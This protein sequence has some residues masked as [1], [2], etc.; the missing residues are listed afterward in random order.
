MV[1][2]M[3]R[4]FLKGANLPAFLWGEAVRHSIY[5]LNR[6]PTR[7]LDGRTPYEAWCGN[8]PDLTHLR[9]FG[10]TAFMK[11]QSVHVR[12][13]DDR[14]KSVVYIDKEPGTKGCRLYDPKTG[15]IHVSRDV[16]CQEGMF[17]PWKREE[18]GEVTFPWNYIEINE[19]A[20]TEES[21]E[22]EQEPMTPLQ[23][24]SSQSRS[25]QSSSQQTMPVTIAESSAETTGG[26]SSSSTSSEPEMYRLLSDVEEPTSY[27]EAAELEEWGDA[28]KSEFETIEKNG[29][30]ALTNW[31][32][33]GV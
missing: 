12:K 31:S 16:V 10:C 2:A 6:L 18:D 8:K 24:P 5:V 25:V 22:T 19:S 9:V 30:W 11:V 33:M 17:W 4:S 27:R 1:A 23:S 7:N 15:A 14:S 28:I 13:L 29:T 21:V 20:E 32:E 26:S 3:T